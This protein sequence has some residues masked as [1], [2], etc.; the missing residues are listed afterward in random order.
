MMLGQSSPQ[1]GGCFFCDMSVR[2]CVPRV[3]MQHKLVPK[4]PPDGV[5]KNT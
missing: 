2:A 1:G 4:N 3:P 5:F